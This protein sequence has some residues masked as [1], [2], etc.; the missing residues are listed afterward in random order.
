[1]FT[2]LA[3]IALRTSDLDR[4]LEFY[5]KLGIRETFRLNHDDGTLMLVYLHIGQDR[6]LELFPGGEAADQ[7]TA[8]S[9]RFMHLCLRSSDLKADVARLEA[10]GVTIEVRPQL[11]LDNNWQAWVIDP[12]GNQIE[13]MELSEESPQRRV[14]RGLT[15]FS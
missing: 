2:D 10:Q 5:A 4:S 6:F 15:P 7:A 11:G 3:H 12:D 13:L 8:F 9:G 1:M 14:A